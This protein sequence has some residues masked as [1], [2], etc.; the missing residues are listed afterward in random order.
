LNVSNK[1]TGHKKA[2]KTHRLQANLSFNPEL[3]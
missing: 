1:K 2:S 3:I